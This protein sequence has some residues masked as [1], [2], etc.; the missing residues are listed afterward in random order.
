MKPPSLQG[1]LATHTSLLALLCDRGCSD[2][3]PLLY[4]IPKLDG[5]PV[6]TL[7]NPSISGANLNWSAGLKWTEE[8]LSEL[9]EPPLAGA[10]FQKYPQSSWAISRV[11]HF[12]ACGITVEP[13]AGSNLLVRNLESGTAVPKLNYQPTY[14]RYRF[15]YEIP[16]DVTA[17]NPRK[18]NLSESYGL[19]RL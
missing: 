16:G 13:R 8:L 15:P 18:G 4:T 2:E 11:G 12:A 1:S 14:V 7:G 9:N 10:I 6:A 3:T 5:R 19:T 17:G